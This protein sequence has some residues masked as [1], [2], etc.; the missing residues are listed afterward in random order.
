M[1]QVLSSARTT[2]AGGKPPYRQDPPGRPRP[3]V[4]LGRVVFYEDHESEV[5][6]ARAGILVDLLCR[7]DH[8]EIATVATSRTIE[9]GG[10]VPE[11]RFE[12][13]CPGEYAVRVRPGQPALADRRA[14]APRELVSLTSGVVMEIEFGVL[15]RL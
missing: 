15:P 10:A 13:A 4:V 1:T 2:I 8:Y 12:I 5:G 11:F 6:Q 3:D 14:P 7:T 9:L